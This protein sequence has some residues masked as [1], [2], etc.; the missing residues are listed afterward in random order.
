VTRARELGLRYAQAN[1]LL[2][3]GDEA[4]A[5]YRLEPV[6]FPLLSVA[7]K[8]AVQRTLERL[9]HLVE[10]DF[11]LWRVYR[12]DPTNNGRSAEI[13]LGVS[14]DTGGSTGLG[15]GLLAAA[16]RLRGRLGDLTDRPPLAG[17][18]IAASRLQELA[19]VEQRTHERLAAITGLRR[20]HTRELQWLL[21]RAAL[22]GVA[23]PQAEP[24]WAPDALIVEDPSGEAVYE[25]LG[26]DLWRLPAAVLVEEPD[27]PPSL[28]VEADEHRG[29]Q[30][31]LA[32]GA[33]AE[34]PVFPGA[35]AELLH[36]PLDAL[37][38]PVDAVMHVRW[39]GN[40]DALA[41][42]RKRIVDAEQTYRDQLQ[43]SLGPQWR[44]EDDRT[45]AREYEE[46]LQSGARP[47][48]L[49]AS[50]SLAVGAT[51]RE[52]LE[53]RVERL[54]TAY[55]DV[56]LHRPR[57]LQ[58][59]LW[60]DH[61]PRVDGGRVRDYVQQLTA[62]QF[63]AMVPTATT[64]IGDQ[65]GALLGRTTGGLAAPVLYDVTAPPR[66]SRPSAVML[67]GTLGSGK[68]VCAQLI[69]LGVLPKDSLVVDF[70]PKDDHGWTNFPALADRLDVL[71]LG[72]GETTAGVLDPLVV[73]PPELRED[74]TLSYLLELL[75]DPPASWEHAIARAVRDTVSDHAHPST[76]AV[77]ERLRG[78]DGSAG[79]EVADALQVIAEVGLGRLGFG[80]G[81]H[82]RE[83]RAVA[84][85][86]TMRIPGL[87]LP[88]Q[89]I[90]RLSY[91]R[92]ERISV[93]TLSLVAAKALQ[94]VS[95][96]RT[97]HK[98][99]IV[100]EAWF[101]FATPAG[102]ALLNRLVRFTRRYNATVLLL[103]QLLE[104][105]ELLRDLVRTWLLFG[106]DAEDQVRLGMSL[107]GVEPTDALVARQQNWQAGRCLM[108]DLRGRVAEIQV[109]PP[110][111]QTLQA[112]NTAPPTGQAALG[113]PE[114]ETD[115]QTM[116]C[117]GRHTERDAGSQSTRRTQCART[118]ASTRSRPRH[119]SRCAAWVPL[120]ALG[121][122]V[123]A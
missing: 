107:I 44:A 43:S 57:G 100:D 29:Y 123:S 20:A 10:A 70:D 34:A 4:L 62:Q 25:P 21:G 13:Y 6:G 65:T 71:E 119:R 82:D 105:L 49:Y 7:S 15:A 32:V 74:L 103:T 47:P 87:T 42:V 54:R 27:H 1:L 78:L 55:G 115:Q 58:E 89:G 69:A 97:R 109:Q 59:R 68:T 84:D 79:G 116:S 104:D 52:L 22:R 3:P 38:F 16:D 90:D 73:A 60:L 75:P 67:A 12:T 50:I 95:L 33:V 112:L 36:A 40:R 56:A 101:L 117:S 45:L 121:R 85:V 46:V 53:R 91:T 35:Q 28:E 108:R 86:T 122:E 24:H 120:A 30:A 19:D 61:L 93:A 23:E 14:L 99:V 96:D 111:P 102:R 106:H 64:V 92:G 66:Q 51:S 110:D 98:V 41:Q 113:D 48:M 76:R 17:G 118:P 72:A 11:S 8:W 2:G 9:A 80:T 5:L 37:G 83:A 88:E 31:M 26:W 114:T 63:G 18:A 94:L 77:L 81:D 39:L